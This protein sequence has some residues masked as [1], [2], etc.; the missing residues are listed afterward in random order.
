MVTM[1][2]HAFAESV[3]LAVT[4]LAFWYGGELLSQG[5][6][7]LREFFI[8]F[9]SVL[10]G[11]QT[12]GVLFGYSSDVSKAHAAANHIIA[13]RD[14]RPPRGT[15][16][17]AHSKCK[18]TMTGCEKAPLI[19]FRNVNFAYASRPNHNVLK[20]LNLSIQKGQSIGI[21]GLQALLV[22]GT[23]LSEQDVHHHRSNIGMVSQDTM[24]FQGSIRENILLGLHD[25]EEDEATATSRVERACRSANMHEFILSLPAGYSTDVGNRGVA[26]SGGQRQRLAI[27]RALIRELD[28]LLFDE[29]TSALDTANEA[30]VQH[31]IESVA[32]ERPDTTTIAVAHRLS[33]I[34][35]CDCIFVLH[36]G[37][38]D[39][40]GT[41]E[42]L[43]A[44][45][46]R[47]YAMVLAQ[48][49]DRET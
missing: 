22:G 12:A 49:L 4:S 13:L 24:L 15:K 35:R 31:S 28:L 16:K 18:I 42:E 43:V 39:E 41:H 30:L 2:V 7:T 8:A 34:K 11:S 46:G 23:P 19:E 44:R 38:V 3:N 47:Y 27:A 5:E 37:E 36:D 40:Q 10:I 6:Y 9:M 48:S 20:G 25:D 29:A 32:R 17:R 45:R 33:T 21:V 14:S 1:L 26:L